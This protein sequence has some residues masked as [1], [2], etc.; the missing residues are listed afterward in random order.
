MPASTWQELCASKRAERDATI[1]KEWLLK[2]LPSEQRANV[3]NVPYE[4]GIMSEQELDLT[5]LDAT[6]LLQRMAQGEL[7]C[8]DVVLAF[9]KRAAIA[10]QLVRSLLKARVTMRQHLVI[11]TQFAKRTQQINCLTMMFVEEALQKAKE[12]DE[13]HE[14]TGKVVGPYHGLPFSIKD[15]WAMKGK[16]SNT[17]IVSQIGYIPQ[18]DAVTVG[19][20]REAGAGKHLPPNSW[21][22]S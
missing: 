9:C 14:R 2:E 20:L 3:M 10:Q 5:E 21:D 22:K 7:K 19:L 18:E 4:C 13:H 12:L 6:E 8:Y 11:M 15:Q 16:E 17:A 1:P